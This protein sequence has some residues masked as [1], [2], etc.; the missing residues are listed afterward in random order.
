MRDDDSSP[1]TIESSAAAH[2]TQVS[3]PALP[4]PNGREFD[5]GYPPSPT[6]NSLYADKPRSPR[7]K[8]LQSKPLFRGFERPSLPRIAILTILCLLTYPAFYVLTLVAKN[9][10]LFMVRS[11]VAVVCWGIGFALG[12]VLLKIGSQH[13]EAASEFISVWYRDLLT[14]YFKQPGPP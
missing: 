5:T 3:P 6:S 9:R 1:H 2:I 10:S 8:L 11:M 4:T 14:L 12:W 7:F 13:L